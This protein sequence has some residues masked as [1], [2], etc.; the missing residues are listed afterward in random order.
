MTQWIEA[1][2]G[3]GEWLQFED[4]ATDDDIMNQL[5]QVYPDMQ[6]PIPTVPTGEEVPPEALPPVPGTQ[7]GG[8]RKAGSILPIEKEYDAINNQMKDTGNW[9]FAMPGFIEGIPQAIETT[10]GMD[11]TQPGG[12]TDEQLDAVLGLSSMGT[13]PLKGSVPDI[14]MLPK[15]PGV[16]TKAP[17]LSVP[18]A[19]EKVISNIEARAAT[20]H[21]PKAQIVRQ[22]VKKFKDQFGETEKSGGILSKE[23]NDALHKMVTEKGG[24]VRRATESLAGRKP[25]ST[26]LDIKTLTNIAFPSAGA[27]MG[28][29]ISPGAASA[30]A[31]GAQAARVGAS[32]LDKSA[33]GAAKWATK[34]MANKDVEKLRTLFHEKPIINQSEAVVKPQGRA[35]PKDK[36]EP[37]LQTPIPENKPMSVMEQY[38]AEEAN[39][40]PPNPSGKIKMTIGEPTKKTQGSLAKKNAKAKQEKANVAGSAQSA[41]KGLLSETPK[42]RTRLAPNK[43]QTRQMLEEAMA[44]REKVKPV[45][46]SS[47]PKEATRGVVSWMKNAVEE[48]QR[49]GIPLSEAVKKW[50][51][52]TD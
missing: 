19:V 26:G 47:A 20:E 43:A 45:Q 17:P 4:D 14:A 12:V 11:V 51:P 35:M 8:W 23:Q 25:I 22:E 27:A 13:I 15:I 33:V 48:S 38:M 30:M 9:R 46:K 18:P 28:G 37:V 2:D 39:K 5:K 41:P 50:R 36:T 52:P 21:I 7:Q 34:R 44:K 32:V 16:G 6:G 31:V 29:Y 1:P 49:T 3:S 42:N 10:K 40:A 24:P